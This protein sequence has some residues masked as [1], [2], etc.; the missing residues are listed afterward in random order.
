MNLFVAQVLIKNPA[1]KRFCKVTITDQN[2]LEAVYLAQHQWEK[3]EEERKR[4]EEEEKR[5]AEAEEAEG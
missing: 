1:I 5:K 2:K 4:I 3:A